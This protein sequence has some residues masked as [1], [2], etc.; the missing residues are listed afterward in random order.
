MNERKD[1]DHWNALAS[2][3][4]AKAA[5]EKAQ[6]D[7]PIGTGAESPPVV[8]RSPSEVKS[9]KPARTPRCSSDWNALANQ[10]GLETPEPVKVEPADQ[11]PTSAGKT[12]TLPLPALRDQ[13]AADDDDIEIDDIEIVAQ[14]SESSEEITSYDTAEPDE[15][16]IETVTEE[17]FEEVIQVRLEAER[18]DA[19]SDDVE[20]V[21]DK[22]ETPTRSRRRGRRRRRPDRDRATEP[23]SS[24]SSVTEDEESDETAPSEEAGADTAEAENRTRRRRRRRRPSRRDPAKAAEPD[25][26]GEI[27]TEID[28]DDDSDEDEGGSADSKAEAD[29]SDSPT[30]KHRKIPTW[31]EAIEVIVTNNLESRS[32]SPNPKGAPR[33]SRRRGRRRS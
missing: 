8:E 15:M 28:D 27:D 16:V 21:G 25:D 26:D 29:D 1:A 23:A 32:N 33:G 30:R 7:K 6:T 2:D 10:L 20:T 22:T 13:L 18:E 5:D 24:E 19:E 4:G 14:R 12:D 31:D 9:P 3:L 17:F 11:E